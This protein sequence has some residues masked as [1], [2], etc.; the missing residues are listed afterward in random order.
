MGGQSHE[1]GVHL[2]GGASI[3]RLAG[4]WHLTHAGRQGWDKQ[5]DG[6][7]GRLGGLE[8][9]DVLYKDGLLQ[10]RG[11]ASEC[12]NALPEAAWARARRRG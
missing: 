3:A 10:C 8:G 4:S 11:L 6:V 5:G 2:I 9:P 7:G 12:V 1:A